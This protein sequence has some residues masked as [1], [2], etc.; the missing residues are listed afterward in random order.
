M[1]WLPRL[2]VRLGESG[3]D[4]GNK[5]QPLCTPSSASPGPKKLWK[6]K[7][8]SVGSCQREKNSKKV[9][10]LALFSQLSALP[11]LRVKEELLVLLPTLLSHH[12]CR[13]C[14]QTPEDQQTLCQV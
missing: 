8:S 5:I 6:L 11:K 10:C 4:Q 13:T 14:P 12:N 2:D 3:C 7:N 9:L 1:C